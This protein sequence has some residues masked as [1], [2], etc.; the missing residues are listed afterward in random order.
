MKK[1]LISLLLL[2][3][4]TPATISVAGVGV[5]SELIDDAAYRQLDQMESNKDQN[6]TQ[7]NPIPSDTDKTDV[8]EQVKNFLRNNFSS[9][10]DETVNTDSSEELKK[11]IERLRN[12][13]QLQE[14]RL[15]NQQIEQ[16]RLRQSM[17]EQRN[18]EQAKIQ[19]ENDYRKRVA[20]EEQKQRR[21]MDER[22][23]ELRR[24]AEAQHI[25]IEESIRKHDIES[26]QIRLENVIQERQ[27]VHSEQSKLLLNETIE[28]YK[29]KLD[30]LLNNVDMEQIKNYEKDFR[31]KESINNCLIRVEE[32]KY[33]LRFANEYN[34]P[35][36]ENKINFYNWK[37]IAIRENISEKTIQAKE[38]QFEAEEQRI[39]AL[40]NI[41]IYLHG[42][43]NY[44]EQLINAEIVKS[45]GSITDKNQAN[46]FILIRNLQTK[47]ENNLPLWINQLSK[48]GKLVPEVYNALIE[49]SQA[50]TEI[51][52]NQI[53]RKNA[54]EIEIEEEAKLK[55][56]QVLKAY[57]LT[58]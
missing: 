17:I 48:S 6:R 5:L 20:E 23:A 8:T 28:F 14:E 58:F 56:N 27:F 54:S 10:A 30:A 57:G 49:V 16:E 51:I 45:E 52:A 50:W 41:N 43:R 3:T 33:D 34:R 55:I 18:A 53:T 11:E 40:A 24:E 38:E 44:F 9:Q 42:Q 47:F 1:K 13:N 29:W 7:T 37:A 19:K 2:A 26:V 15:R 4:C 36:L 25:K 12:E 22:N 46:R 31:K 35:L 21:Q 39:F 32:A